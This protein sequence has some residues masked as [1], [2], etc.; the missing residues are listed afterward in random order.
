MEQLILLAIIVIFSIID[1]VARTNKKKRQG[2]VPAPSGGTR[3][4][5]QPDER[6]PSYDE[7]AVES[8]SQE[9]TTLPRYT[10]PYGSTRVQKRE[11][12]TSSEGMVPADIW[13]EI[14]GLARGRPPVRKAPPPPPP[15]PPAPVEVAP[16]SRRA[17]PSSRIHRSHAA[18][19]TDPSKRARSEQDGLDPMRA[20]L[21]RDAASARRQLKGH[22]KHALRQAV[23]LQEI[24]GRPA[25]M[26]GDPFPE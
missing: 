7:V 21:G 9:P 19:G 25:A 26:R 18:Y 1:S 12:P 13:Q 10:K 16:V 3:P 4:E 11:T 20:T 14:Q 5:W 15:P 17:M 24:L 2:S 6:E 23:I 22:K 8:A